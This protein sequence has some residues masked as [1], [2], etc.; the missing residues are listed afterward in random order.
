MP[1][2]MTASHDVV[3]KAMI[4]DSGL[5]GIPTVHVFGMLFVPG[6]DRNR[7]RNLTNS[8]LLH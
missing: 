3:E 5:S 7:E 2:R 8:G 1:D 4:I 6:L